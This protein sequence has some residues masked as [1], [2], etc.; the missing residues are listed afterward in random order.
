MPSTDAAPDEFEPM[1]Q[2]SPPGSDRFGRFLREQIDRELDSLR[3]V[4]ENT[5]SGSGDV[6]PHLSLFRGF[7]ECELKSR[8]LRMHL[9][10]GTGEGPCDTIGAVF[11]PEDERGCLTR[12]LLGLPYSDRP[13][14]LPRWRP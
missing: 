14:Y 4:R 2:H 9:R 7:R 11:P 3:T 10:C 8:L 1:C 6:L 13:G 12:A 5:E